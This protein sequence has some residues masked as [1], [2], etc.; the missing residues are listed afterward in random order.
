M[1]IKSVSSVGGQN[2]VK[3]VRRVI[4]RSVGFMSYIVKK[5]TAY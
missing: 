4:R 2:D 1:P 3:V 5:L